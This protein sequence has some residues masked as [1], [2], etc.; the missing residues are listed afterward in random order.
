MADQSG[1]PSTSAPG[2][3]GGD[4]AGTHRVGY[5]AKEFLEIYPAL[6]RSFCPGAHAGGPV[7]PAAQQQWADYA[8]QYYAYYAAAAQQQQQAQMPAP[9]ADGSIDPLAGFDTNQLAEQYLKNAYAGYDAVGSTYDTVDEYGVAALRKCN[10]CGESGHFSKECPTA[11]NCRKCGEPGH[12]QRVCPQSEC[13]HVTTSH[14]PSLLQLHER[15]LQHI[16]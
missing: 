9:G 8:Q 3:P 1:A 13:C 6:L 16:N 14:S 2:V 12:N 5:I 11:R 10:S 15:H 7:D 4:S